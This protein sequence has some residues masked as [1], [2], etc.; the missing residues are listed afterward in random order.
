MCLCKPSTR[1]WVVGH[2]KRDLT[3]CVAG[4]SKCSFNSQA[5]AF[6]IGLSNIALSTGLHI[7]VYVHR[8]PCVPTLPLSV[9]CKHPRPRCCEPAAR[10][11]FGH[12][13]CE[14]VTV[15]DVVLLQAHVQA[16]SITY[17]PP[18]TYCPSGIP[19]ASLQCWCLC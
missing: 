2:I 14:C 1:S 9:G 4:T 6:D 10:G 17:T 19:S 13:R 18:F 5:A 11:L 12:V 3:V 15:Q 16:T 8:R 7:N